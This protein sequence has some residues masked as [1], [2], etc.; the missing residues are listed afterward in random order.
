MRPIEMAMAGAV[1]AAALAVPAWPT[2]TEAPAAG[3]WSA[4]DVAVTFA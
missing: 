1:L 4:Q 3:A 2:E